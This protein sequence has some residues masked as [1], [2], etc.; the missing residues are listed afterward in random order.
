MVLTLS[1]IAVWLVLILPEYDKYVLITFIIITTAICLYGLF[2]RKYLIEAFVFPILISAIIMPPLQLTP[3]LPFIR[4]EVYI[5]ILLILLIFV[6]GI[7]NNN[8]NGILQNSMQKWFVFLGISILISFIYSFFVLEQ[9]LIIRDFYELFKPALYF[10]IFSL[11]ASRNFKADEILRIY[12]LTMALFFI[13]MLVGFAQY[14][15]FWRINELLTPYYAPTQVR[16]VLEV[17][18]IS[19]TAYSPVEFGA[20]MVLAASLSLANIFLFAKNNWRVF[21]L[22]FLSLFT[23]TLLLTQTRAAYIAFLCSALYIIIYSVLRSLR[24]IKM[25]KDFFIFISIFLLIILLAITFTPPE[26]ISRAAT[27]LDLSGD[28]SWNYRLV[29]WTDQFERWLQSP[30]FGWGPDKTALTF[31]FVEN[32][33]LLV[34]RRYGLLGIIAFIALWIAFIRGLVRIR[35]NLKAEEVTFFSVGLQSSILGYFLYM[36]TTNLYH[37]MIL[38]YILMILLGIIYSLDKDSFDKEVYI[39]D[40]KKF[41]NCKVLVIS[42]MYPS[43]IDM[44]YGIFVHKQ[45]M[46]LQRQGCEVRVINPVPIAPFPINLFKTKWR[47]FNKLKDRSFIDGVKIYHPKFFIMPGL[48]LYHYSGLFMYYGIK[49][50]IKKIYREFNFNLIHAHTALPDGFAGAIIK[51]KY[52]KPLIVTIHGIDL[53][54][55]IYRNKKCLEAVKKVLIEANKV[56][57]VSSKLKKIAAEQLNNREKAIVIGNG[58]DSASAKMSITKVFKHNQDSIE[59]K[60]IILS[61]AELIK[62]KGLDINI[63]AIS[64]IK[65]KYPKIQYFI[66][67]EGPEESNLLKLRERL[68]LNDTVHFLGKL[69]HEEVIR[70]MAQ[71]DVFSLPS[72]NEAFG[73]VYIEAMALGIPVIACRGEG[74]ED[75]IYS[76]E[77]GILVTPKDVEDLTVKLDFLISKPEKAQSIARKGQALVLNKYTWEENAKKTIALYSEVLSNDK[78]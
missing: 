75:V 53:Y 30:L 10:L 14:F 40:D 45:V 57:C 64:Y 23:L 72:W 38:I 26:I 76:G 8:L 73:V 28:V 25:I 7:Y 42:H 34:L 4:L 21:S 31:E 59:K 50:V 61:V 12:G 43:P 6:R 1:I 47:K 2:K 55:T 71:A 63:K 68:G 20:L 24:S 22:F 78:S 16:N 19:G 35:N 32:E 44:V 46:E 9:T 39:E 65:N 5:S 69:P 36:V 51:I 77:N 49:K 66:I 54:D 67:G 60:V 52:N 18:R 41:S 74:I 27:L 3:G 56:I 58:V 62:R 15:D 11:F 29:R 13:S 48:I 70:Y 33:W 17:K 37:S